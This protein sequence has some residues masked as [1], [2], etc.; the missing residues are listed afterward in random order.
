MR[1]VSRQ[2][3]MAMPAG[4][5]YQTYEPCN[6]GPFNVKA[7]TIVFE[8]K[9]IDWFYVVGISQPDF[10]EAD[11]SE[12]WFAACD[13]MERGESIPTHIGVLCRDGLFDDRQLYAVWDSDDVARLVSALQGIAAREPSQ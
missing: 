3:L 8:G 13:R 10:E 9:A 11:S 7:E 4:T 6:F 5:V 12:T 2:S 1:I